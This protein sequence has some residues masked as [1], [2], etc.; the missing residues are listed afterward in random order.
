[1]NLEDLVPILKNGDWVRFEACDYGHGRKYIYGKILNCS[2]VAQT[3]L[4][5][6]LDEMRFTAGGYVVLPLSR[7]EKLTDEQIAELTIKLL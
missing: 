3:L 6:M 4:S 1:M 2:N 7:L 5:V